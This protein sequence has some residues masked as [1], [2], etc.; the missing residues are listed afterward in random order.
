MAWAPEPL[1]DPRRG[2]DVHFDQLDPACQVAGELLERGADH[3]AGPA[4][5]RP[6]VDE[7]RNPGGLGDLPEGGVVSISDPRQRLMALSATGRPGRCHR[8]PVGLAA[9]PALD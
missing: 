9:V 2:V 5:G 1:R 4:P 3:A 6:Q 8:N 7:D